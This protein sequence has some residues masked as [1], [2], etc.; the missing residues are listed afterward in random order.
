MNRR[1]VLK[2]LSLSAALLP[3]QAMAAVWHKAAFNA[4]GTDNAE[5]AL[6]INAE[7]ASDLIDIK[8]PKKAENGAIVQLEV[9]SRV[10]NSEAAAVF[11]DKNPTALITNI[12]FEAGAEA[13]FVTRVKMAETSDIKVIIKSG[14]KYFTASKKVIVLENGCGNG[15]SANGQF[16]SSTK[17]RAKLVP[18]AD[19]LV[20]VKAIIT[21]PMHTGYAKDDFG[22]IVPAHFIQALT[23]SH[24]D[25][26]AVE[27][28][29]GTGISKNPY[30]TFYLKQAK[31]DDIVTLQWHDNKGNVGQGK[32]TVIS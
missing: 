6:D 1:S 18:D 4:V 9:T 25:K 20:K 11:I 15:G 7:I 12:M 17:M 8:A 29:L 10:P 26:K 31:L 32:T 16:T 24:N 21:H 27:M 14:S 23:I 19:G 13:N 30:L 5:Q 22:E 3:L 2:F 28:H